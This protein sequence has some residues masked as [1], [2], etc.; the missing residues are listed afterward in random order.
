[1]MMIGDEGE[2]GMAND[3]VITEIKTF[4]KTWDF[5]RNFSKIFKNTLQDKFTKSKM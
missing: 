1:M 4:R 3:D 5:S 2:R